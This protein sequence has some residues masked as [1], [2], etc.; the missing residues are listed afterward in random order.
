MKKQNAEI[1]RRTAIAF[2]VAVVIY[3]VLAFVNRTF[4]EKFETNEYFTNYSEDDVKKFMSNSQ[5]S[6]VLFY[7]PW[8]GYCKKVKPTWMQ[9]QN[10]YKNSKHVGI[11]EVNCDEYP[12]FREEHGIKSFPTIRFYTNGPKD[13]HNYKE[14]D[15]ERTFDAIK[16]YID[17]YL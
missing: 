8:C 12:K 17:Q 10:Y 5:K 15:G 13:K 7:A 1:L 6:I 9:L 11:Y 16:S 2:A 4:K 3:V 14:H